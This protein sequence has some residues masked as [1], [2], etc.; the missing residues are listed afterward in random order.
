[1]HTPM[2]D[3]NG[4]PVARPLARLEAE[5]AFYKEH[6][7]KGPQALFRAVVAIYATGALLL[8]WLKIAAVVVSRRRKIS[9]RR[10]TE[11]LATE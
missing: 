10:D 6:G 2:E 1:M 8:Q 7:G 11:P 9:R 4:V 5:D 3:P